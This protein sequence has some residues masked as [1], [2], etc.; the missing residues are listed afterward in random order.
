[1]ARRSLRMLSLTF[2]A[3]AFA[4][5]AAP[6]SFAAQPEPKPFLQGL[7]FPTNL[8]FAPDGRLFYTEK[9]TGNVRIVHDGT[10]RQEPFV[11]LPVVP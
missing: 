8:A 11:T 1:M 3:F 5:F 6:R 2:A 4:A 9:S 7:A 10:L